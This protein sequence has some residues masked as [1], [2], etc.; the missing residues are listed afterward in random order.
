MVR[1]LLPPPLH[2]EDVLDDPVLHAGTPGGVLEEPDRPLDGP[3]VVGGVSGPERAAELV[4][5][6][7][8]G[9]L[10][11]AHCSEGGAV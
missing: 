9:G 2:Q 3:L 10:R 8:A 5:H 6:D 4:A 7:G 11:E 1:G